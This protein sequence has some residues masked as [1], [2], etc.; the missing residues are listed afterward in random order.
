VAAC[1]CVELVCCCSCGRC[2]AMKCTSC[3]QFRKTRVRAAKAGSRAKRALGRG[4]RARAA[5]RLGGG[6]RAAPR[7]QQEQ[8]RRPALVTAYRSRARCTAACVPAGSAAWP[9]CRS[10]SAAACG[11][12]PAQ[13]TQRAGVSGSGRKQAVRVVSTASSAAAAC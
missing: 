1:S 11:P 13:R 6:R 5:P 8:A 4:Y 9:C 2:I 7:E 10:S 12:G 3:Q